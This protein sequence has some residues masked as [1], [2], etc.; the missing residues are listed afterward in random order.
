MNAKVVFSREGIEK[1]SFLPVLVDKHLRPEVLHSG[2]PH[3]DNAL[4][5]VD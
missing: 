2:G 4:K 1:T 5:Y 3:F